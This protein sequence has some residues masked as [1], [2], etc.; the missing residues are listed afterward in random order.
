MRPEHGMSFRTLRDRPPRP[1][2]AIWWACLNWVVV[3]NGAVRDAAVPVLGFPV[4]SEVHRQGETAA[5]LITDLNAPDNSRGSCIR[6]RHA[7]KLPD[8]LQ[9]VR[10]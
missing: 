6:L 10:R 5:T 4:P 7:K 3:A 1:V 8:G 9:A 2:N